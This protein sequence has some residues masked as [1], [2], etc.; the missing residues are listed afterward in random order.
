MP[1]RTFQPNRRHRVKTHGF[2]AR[3]KTKAGAAVLSRRRPQARCS[4]R[5]LPRL[6]LPYRR[7]RASRTLPSRSGM[8]M[9]P[10]RFRIKHSPAKP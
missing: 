3:M 1:K 9:K 4:E 5:R 2:R 6:T 10:P 8:R 7:E